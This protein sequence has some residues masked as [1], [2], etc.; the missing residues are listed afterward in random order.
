MSVLHC[1]VSDG[2]GRRIV[3]GCDDYLVKVMRSVECDLREG[4]V[5]C[6]V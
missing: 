3:T 4:S 1:L 6:V 5:T 2:A